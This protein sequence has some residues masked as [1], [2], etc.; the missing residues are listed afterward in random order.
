MPKKQLAGDITAAAARLQVLNINAQIGEILPHLE[1]LLST[2][3]PPV[4]APE[5]I[6]E[7]APEVTQKLDEP[8]LLHSLESLLVQLRNSDMAATNASVQVQEKFGA[9]LGKHLE[10]LNLA[11]ANLDFEQ[12]TDCVLALITFIQSN[13]VKGND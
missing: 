5:I 10:P 6:T 7:V 9:V 3:Q 12:A 8:A 13:R 4:L 11:M 1:A 2:L